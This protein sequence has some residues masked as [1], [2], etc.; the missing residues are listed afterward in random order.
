MGSWLQPGSLELRA[1]GPPIRNNHSYTVSLCRG[2]LFRIGSSRD[3]GCGFRCRGNMFPSDSCS[4][5]PSA[6]MKPRAA[7]ICCYGNM[8]SWPSAICS[9]IR[10][11]PGAMRTWNPTPFGRVLGWSVPSRPCGWVPCF[12]SASSRRD[13]LLY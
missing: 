7:R 6:I 5:S 2:R 11:P 10:A 1:S 12:P 13:S 3:Q 4:S 8:I 9:G